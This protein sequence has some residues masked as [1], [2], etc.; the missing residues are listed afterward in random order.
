MLYVNN[1]ICAPSRG[2][3]VTGLYGHNSGIMG[4]MKMSPEC[5]TPLIMEVVREHGYNVGIMSKVD[6]ST[7][8]ESFEWDFVKEDSEL[9]FGR[10]PD[11]YYKNAK[12]FF[13]KTKNQA[14][15]FILW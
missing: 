11:L 10:N 9:G 14:N 8:K 5:K 2:I 1:S 4:F 6:H 3:L 12:D 7:P 13:Q 15:L